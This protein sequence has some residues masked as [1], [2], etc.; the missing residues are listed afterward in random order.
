MGHCYFTETIGALIIGGVETVRVVRVSVVIE[1]P[2][3][4]SDAINQHFVRSYFFRL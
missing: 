2:E 3:I 4:N 1:N